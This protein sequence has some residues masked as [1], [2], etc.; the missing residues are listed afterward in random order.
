M[1]DFHFAKRTDWETS[2]NALTQTCEDLKARGLMIKDL[3][4]SNPTVCGFSSLAAGWLEELLDPANL[5]YTPDPRGLL[6]AREAVVRYYA[7]HGIHVSPERIFLTSSTSEGY[8]YVFRLIANAGERIMFPSPSY[9]LFYFLGDLND[10][11]LDFYNLDFAGRWRVDRDSVRQ[12]MV[13]D[14]RA[15]VV[16]NPNNPT[17]SYCDRE[18]QEFLRRVCGRSTALISDEVFLDYSQDGVKPLSLAG[19]TEALTFVLSGLS[20]VL[21]MPQMKLSWIVVAGPEDLARE[22]TCRLEVLADT[23]LSVSA[24][25]QHAA[26]VWLDRRHEVQAEIRQRLNNNL[27]FLRNEL[28][29]S[30]ANV[31]PVEG[32]WYAVIG[33][34]DQR[35]EEDMVL[36]FLKRD[37]VLVHPGYFFD[38]SGTTSHLVLSLLTEPSVWQTGVR[39]IRDYL[40]FP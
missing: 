15:M 16:V 20:K 7:G 28:A 33:L 4:V 22:A 8:S 5:R 14:T 19:E 23:Y 38:F 34:P 36:D 24:P 3:T 13:E 37:Q 26:G 17:G 40:Q 12:K 1:A 11:E 25:V 29:D 2:T 30:G 32:G 27:I 35:D 31:Y 39:A 10:V 9:P 18:D 6:S 21:A